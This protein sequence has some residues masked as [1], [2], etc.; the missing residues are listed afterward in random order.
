MNITDIKSELDELTVALI[1]AARDV[2]IKAQIMQAASADYEELKQSMLVALFDQEAQDKMRRT[3]AQRTA[4]VRTK[5]AMERRLRNTAQADYESAKA[6]YKGLES[7]L[8]ALQTLAGIERDEMR[9]A[10]IN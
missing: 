7:K 3:E 9:M 10:Q 6:F 4:I 2:G 1:D 8:S 5:Y